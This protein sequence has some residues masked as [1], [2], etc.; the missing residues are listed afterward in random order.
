MKLGVIIFPDF[1]CGRALLDVF[2]RVLKVSAI[3]IWHM[4]SKLSGFDAVFVSG[5]TLWLDSIRGTQEISPIVESLFEFSER[6]KY[7]F[8][9]G[10][11]F[12][13]LCKM[14]LLPGTFAINKD[15]RFI[16]RN[17]YVRVDNSKSALTALID[18]SNC[19]KLPLS[20]AYGRYQATENEL[21]S[22]RQNEQIL[23]R[24]CNDQAKI[25]EK[26]NYT[27][28]VDNIASL[29]NENFTVFGLLPSP[30]RA[31]EEILG[32]SDGRYIFESIL[33][34]IK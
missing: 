30:E 5:G 20:C 29:S 17:V 6:K 1:D 25:F 19:L 24:Y 28:S 11:G 27:G 34:W 13:L 33:A 7:I 9:M 10:E 21:I 14:K 12:R 8:G 22:I 15:N 3:P 26:I 18:K 23:F 2:N 4:E 32:N 31:S 16:S